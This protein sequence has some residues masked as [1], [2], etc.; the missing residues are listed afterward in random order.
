MLKIIGNAL[1]ISMDIAGDMNVSFI[2]NYGSGKEA[3][4]RKG[5][6]LIYVGPF[7]GFIHIIDIFIEYARS[8]ITIPL[9]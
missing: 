7:R 2:L 6:Q 5:H 4:K 1:N 9:A 8:Y 3:E